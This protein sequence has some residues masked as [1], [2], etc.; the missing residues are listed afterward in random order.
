[1]TSDREPGRPY[2]S[3]YDTAPPFP[4]RRALV[5]GAL[6][7]V[8]MVALMLLVRPALFSVAPP[9]GDAN[10]G[11]ASADEL[12]AGPISRP[13]LLTESRGLL[14]ERVEGR[15]RAIT[16]IV[17]QLPGGQVAVVNA[18]SPVDPCA[19]TVSEDRAALVDCEGRRWGLDG[20]PLEGG[21]QPALQRFEASM[22]NG[23]VVADL[24][25]PVS[26]PGA[27]A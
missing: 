21:A 26:G 17:S 7:F 23:A 12:V 18:W 6:A 9:R 5:G 25:A 1:M 15:N 11:I 24:T 13:I 16:V 20:A 2:E 10:L 14:G 19:V 4:L 27:G 8:A 22:N 3:T